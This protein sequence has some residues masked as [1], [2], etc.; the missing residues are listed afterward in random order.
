[1]KI[2][3]KLFQNKKEL[4]NCININ[5]SLCHNLFNLLKYT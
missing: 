2:K 1:M 5:F 3:Y 4:N